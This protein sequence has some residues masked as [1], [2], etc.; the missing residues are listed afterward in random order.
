MEGLPVDSPPPRPRI[1]VP[2]M[3]SNSTEISQDQSLSLALKKASY[4]LLI[5]IN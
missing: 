2:W 5:F 3:L 1:N 4:I